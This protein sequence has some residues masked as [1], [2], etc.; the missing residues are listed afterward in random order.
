LLLL[1]SAQQITLLAAPNKVSINSD[2]VLAIDGQKVFPIGF[3]TPPPPDGKT[4]DGKNAIKELSDAGATF[5][6]TGGRWT[7]EVPARTSN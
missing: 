6:R 1:F 2:L 4:P 3:T 5:L 7:R